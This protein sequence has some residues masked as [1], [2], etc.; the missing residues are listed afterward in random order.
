[1]VLYGQWPPYNPNS[2]CVILSCSLTKPRVFL[3]AAVTVSSFNEAEAST[4]TIS[5]V[6]LEKESATFSRFN[7]SHS[8]TQS[9]LRLAAANKF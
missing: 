2:Y 7:V 1:M 4:A 6:S 8:H 3:E 9:K 5:A